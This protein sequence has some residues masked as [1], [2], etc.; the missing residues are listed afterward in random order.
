[1]GAAA[2]ES[3]V[4]GKRAATLRFA[5]HL[6]KWRQ[7]LRGWHACVNSC[8]D[9]RSPS[10]RSWKTYWGTSKDFETPRATRARLCALVSRRQ[11]KCNARTTAME[12]V[13]TIRTR[14]RSAAGSTMTPSRS[15]TARTASRRSQPLKSSEHIAS[16]SESP[17]VE[18]R[19]QSIRR[20]H[21]LSR[22]VARFSVSQ[23]EN[24]VNNGNYYAMTHRLSRGQLT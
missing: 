24:I 10:R 7:R 23:F 8:V 5:L 22:S 4:N 16:P 20:P 3:L 18:P 21:I 14:A 1:M 6:G 19:Q 15:A 12:A 9:R 2:Q 13:Q 17:R 11:T